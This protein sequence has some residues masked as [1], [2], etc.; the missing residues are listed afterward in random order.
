MPIISTD[1]KCSCCKVIINESRFSLSSLVLC[2]KV[3]RDEFLPEGFQYLFNPHVH[4][5]RL[6][7]KKKVEL[8]I[9]CWNYVKCVCPMVLSMVNH[10]YSEAVYSDVQWLVHRAMQ[11]WRQASLAT[12]VTLLYLQMTHWHMLASWYCSGVIPAAVHCYS[13]FIWRI[14][15][16]CTIELR[17]ITVLRCSKLHN[18]FR[19]RNECL[20]A[21]K[22]MLELQLNLLLILRKL[23][24]CLL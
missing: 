14:S 16:P 18:V 24:C 20:K 21:L 7:A 5:I 8:I 17:L 4:T 2:L 1:M 12:L 10:F 19:T 11:A 22:N 9:I 13:S 3:Y 23:L 6:R 15:L